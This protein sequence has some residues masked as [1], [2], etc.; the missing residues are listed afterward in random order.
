[1]EQKKFQS[2]MEQI[3]KKKKSMEIIFETFTKHAQRVM[4]SQST[5]PDA[6]P[7]MSKTSKELY[8]TLTNCNE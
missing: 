2:L 5:S 7:A 4:K 1:M 6:T 3:N 8:A